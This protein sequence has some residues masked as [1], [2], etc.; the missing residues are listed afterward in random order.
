MQLTKNIAASEVTCKCGCGLIPPQ[1][2]LN[3]VQIIREICGFPFVISSG[4]RCENYNKKIGATMAHFHGAIDIKIHGQEAYKLIE[5]AVGKWMTGIGVKQH[6]PF[7][8]RFI[9]LDDIVHPKF[10]RPMIWS[11]Q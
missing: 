10:P 4:A 6:G 1:R 7:E 2:F 3:K 8:R 9:H 5:V 11:Y